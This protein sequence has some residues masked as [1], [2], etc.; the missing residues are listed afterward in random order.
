MVG[1]PR[2]DRRR[3]D[4]KIERWSGHLGQVPAVVQVVPQIQAEG[5]GRVT[6]LTIDGN[7][8]DVRVVKDGLTGPTVWRSSAT[9]RSSWSNAARA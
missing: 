7:R 1:R 4:R 3:D 8:A 2:D 9:R 6:E 5:Q